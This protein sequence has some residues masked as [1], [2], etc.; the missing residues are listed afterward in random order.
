MN[1]EMTD[2][3]T[4][5][6]KAANSQ[7]VQDLTIFDKQQSTEVFYALR[8]GSQSNSQSNIAIARNDK[9]LQSFNN[10]QIPQLEKLLPEEQRTKHSANAGREVPQLISN[11]F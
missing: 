11:S 7:S 9:H 8:Q 5:F 4:P 3:S 6:Q 10:S 2:F 1:H